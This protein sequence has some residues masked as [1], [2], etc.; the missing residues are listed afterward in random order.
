MVMTPTPAEAKQRIKAAIE[1][2]RARW[3]LYATYKAYC[4]DKQPLTFASEEYKDAFA[5]MISRYRENLCPAVVNAL[6]DRLIVTGFDYEGPSAGAAAPQ[7]EASEAEATAAQVITSTTWR[8]WRDN[9]M[10]HRAGQVMKEAARCGDAFVL[11]WPDSE[12]RPRITPQDPQAMQVHYPDEGELPDWAAKWWLLEDKRARLNIYTPEAIEKWV[13]PRALQG[14]KMPTTTIPDF[15]P[16]PEEPWIEN[17]FGRVPVFH[18]AN[19]ADIGEYGTSELKDVLPIQDALNKSV[20]DI[21][22]GAEFAAFPQRYATG[23]QVV[24]DPETGQPVKSFKP[25]PDRLWI[26]GSKDAEFGQ[27]MPMQL[28]QLLEERASFKDAIADVTGTPTHYLRMNPTSWPSGESLKTAEARFVSKVR[29]RQQG[30]GNAWE[31]V[32]AFAALQMG[33]TIDGRL[34]TLWQDASPRS[35]KD[36]AETAILKKQVGVSNEQLQRELGYSDEQIEKMGEESAEAAEAATERMMQS[37]ARF[38]AR[39]E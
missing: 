1:L 27:F 14:G 29:D 21:L 23:I 17:K 13:T 28:E 16:W 25:G 6:A 20:A 31:D 26:S 18:F 4:S 10:D 12:G 33:M 34:S 19:D 37:A 15:V 11:V 30:F 35:D 9:R 3:P 39:E 7:G 22:V 8:I 5:K 24:I 36:A 32:I 38:D 2:L